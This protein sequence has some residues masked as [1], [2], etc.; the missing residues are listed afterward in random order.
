MSDLV[1]DVARPDEVERIRELQ[2]LGGRM[3]EDISLERSH[4]FVHRLGSEPVAW[5]GIELEPPSALLRSLFTLPEHRRLGIGGRLVRHAERIAA[6]RGARAMYLFST[7]AGAFFA[8]HGYT[9][10]PV[11]EAVAA[12]PHVPQ[13][14]W[15]L[16]RPWLLDAEVSFRREL[17]R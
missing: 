15:Y 16:E 6:A 8:A 17:S 10:V 14:E 5:V 4:F 7:G 2:R 1:F 9:E 12:L 13:L 11:G 3:W